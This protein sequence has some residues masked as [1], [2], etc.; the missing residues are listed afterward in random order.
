MILQPMLKVLERLMLIQ[1]FVYI[2]FHKLLFVHFILFLL[3]S[4]L[5]LVFFNQRFK[6]ILFIYIISNFS[7]THQG[8]KLI[9]N[10]P[11]VFRINTHRKSRRNHNIR[12]LHNT[13]NI[14]LFCQLIKINVSRSFIR[15]LSCKQNIFICTL[16][17]ICDITWIWFYIV[18]N[19]LLVSIKFSS[20]RSIIFNLVFLLLLIWNFEICV[21]L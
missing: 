8:K 7:F 21:F 2:R 9:I 13:W 14:K 6:S 20:Y 3:D 11:V 18:V 10:L 5:V 19:F 12:S 17:I 15:L 1:P 16:W 4:M